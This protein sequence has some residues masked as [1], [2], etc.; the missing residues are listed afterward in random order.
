M[1]DSGSLLLDG[2]SILFALIQLPS[3]EAIFVFLCEQTVTEEKA[4][5]R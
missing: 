4:K 2:L 1:L 3:S 5:Q